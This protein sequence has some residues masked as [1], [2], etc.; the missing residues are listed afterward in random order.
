MDPMSYAFIGHISAAGPN[1]FTSSALDTTGADFIAIVVTE[2]TAGSATISDSKSNTW[3]ILSEQ[4]NS[5]NPS[6]VIYYAAATGKTGSGH[7]FTAT[8]SSIFSVLTVMAFSGAKVSAPIDVQAGTGGAG[9][10]N[11]AAPGSI[12]PTEDNELIISGFAW[13]AAMTIT[14]VTGATAFFQTNFTGGTNYGGGGAYVIQTTAGAINM[15]WNFSGSVAGNIVTA[16][17]KAAPASDPPVPYQ[18]YM[19]GILTQ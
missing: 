18:T 1:T 14:S 8:G 15:A 19:A 6:C 7:T 5:I 2:N 11:T 10:V 16:S 3:N 9:F 4:T 13:N 17:F 12:T